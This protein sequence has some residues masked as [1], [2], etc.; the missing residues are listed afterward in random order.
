MVIGANDMNIGFNLNIT[1]S[2]DDR[3]W[4]VNQAVAPLVGAIDGVRDAIGSQEEMLAAIKV[5]Q[6]RVE[7]IDN[8]SQ[9]PKVNP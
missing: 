7:Q 5:L 2:D 6:S 9:T 3:A 4:L 8:Q 1:L